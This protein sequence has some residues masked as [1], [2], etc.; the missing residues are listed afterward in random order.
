MSIIY[1]VINR[2]ITFRNYSSIPSSVKELPKFLE[3]VNATHEEGEPVFTGAHQN[4]GFTRLAELIEHLSQN[5][6]DIGKRILNADNKEEICT[7]LKAMPHIGDFFSWQ[8]C[9][10]LIESNVIDFGTK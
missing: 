5:F 10:D 1:R 9:C 4:M 7:I 6:P 8:I 3:W 2:H